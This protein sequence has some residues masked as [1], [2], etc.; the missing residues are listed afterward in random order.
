MHSRSLALMNRAAE[1][2][3]GEH[4]KLKTQVRAALRSLHPDL[5]RAELNARAPHGPPVHVGV[6]LPGMRTPSG[7][8]VAIELLGARAMS[9]NTREAFG[10]WLMRRR[11]L[12]AGGCCAIGVPVDTFGT[13]G[14]AMRQSM[15]R[16]ALRECGCDVAVGRGSARAVAA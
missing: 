3:D 12:A 1:K 10:Q 8:P 5:A 13:A 15:L 9:S 7:H 14:H 6:L 11:Q 16:Q 2:A 4:R